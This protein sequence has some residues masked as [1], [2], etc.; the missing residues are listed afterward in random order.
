M[1]LDSKPLFNFTTK[2]IIASLGNYYNCIVIY[3]QVNTAYLNKCLY[4]E[5]SIFFLSNV[6]TNHL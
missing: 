5:R 1:N 4:G 6:L 3:S 2:H